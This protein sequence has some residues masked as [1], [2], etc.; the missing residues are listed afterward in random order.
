V[1]D[2]DYIISLNKP[3]KDFCALCE[4][5]RFTTHPAEDEIK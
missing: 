1:C 3:V 4:E 5:Q 2:A